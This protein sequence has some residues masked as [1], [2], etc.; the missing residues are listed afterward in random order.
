MKLKI[1]WWLTCK[2][3][4][5]ISVVT[6]VSMYY[7][8]VIEAWHAL[9]HLTAITVVEVALFSELRSMKNLWR[10]C[11]HKLVRFF[12][13]PE[14]IGLEGYL[15]NSFRTFFEGCEDRDAV[16]PML[17]STL[18]ITNIKFKHTRR[19]I[20]MIITLERPGLL[21]GKGG[22]TIKQLQRELSLGG[23]KEVKF[24]LIQSRIWDY[25]V[26]WSS[27]NWGKVAVVVLIPIM[28]WRLFVYAMDHNWF[29]VVVYTGTLTGG[30]LMLIKKK[31][32]VC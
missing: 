15:K 1:N 19:T 25:K 23:Y 11:K 4:L 2:I 5:L 31:F 7:I 32:F 22:N 24:R 3:L 21:I 10:I 26:S 28:V 6:V 12:V 29:A 18:G 16:V 27:I 14:M 8:G 20:T 30:V 13:S 9:F 17:I